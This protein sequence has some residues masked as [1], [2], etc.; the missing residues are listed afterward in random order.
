MRFFIK[1]KR[2]Y[3]RVPNGKEFGVKN[4]IVVSL[5]H[6]LMLGARTF[7]GTAF[8]GH[9]LRGLLEQAINIS[10]DM[11]V[12]ITHVVGELGYRGVDEENPGK[13]IIHRGK[14]KSL[15]PQQ[16]GWLRRR[17]AIEPAIGHLKSDHRLDR[18]RLQGALGDALQPAAA[19]R[20][21]ACV[22]CC[23]PMPARVSGPPFCACVGWCS[24][25]PSPHGR[26]WPRQTR[27]SL[28][29]EHRNAGVV[30]SHKT[31]VVGVKSRWRA[32][33]TNFAGPTN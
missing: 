23:A 25:Q 1:H 20:A 18:C 27:C 11:N 3:F 4:A 6:G 24:K 29:P 31:P 32:P 10:Q 22:G 2:I 13:L 5:K 17:E 9:I 26:W 8:D 28:Q 7:P 33:S 14:I 15:S 12:T 21:T 30:D 16:E 19:R